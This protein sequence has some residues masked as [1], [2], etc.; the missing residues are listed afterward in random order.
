MLKI[1]ILSNLLKKPKEGCSTSCFPSISLSIPLSFWS[2]FPI[3]HVTL[4]RPFLWYSYHHKIGR[5]RSLTFK[6]KKKR[7]KSIHLFWG[8]R[9]TLIFCGFSWLNLTLV[10]QNHLK[11]RCR[12][13]WEGMGRESR[14]IPICKKDIT[15]ALS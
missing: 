15:V 12:N 7:K 13:T 8:G 3:S 6:K 2:W 14:I 11:L 10:C 4:Y 5:F 1:S 9:H